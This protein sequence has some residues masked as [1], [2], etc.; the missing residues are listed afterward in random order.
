M[1]PEEKIKICALC[2][3]RKMSLQKGIVCGLTDEKPQFEEACE[4]YLVD[5]KEVAIEKERLEDEEHEIGENNTPAPE[6]GALPGAGWFK[7]IAILSILNIAL[8]FIDVSFIFGLA[9]TQLLQA[10]SDIRLI[11]PIVGVFGMIAIP[12][13]FYLTWWLTA[14]KGYKLCYNVG[15]AIYALDTVLLVLLMMQSGE[16]S[17]LIPELIFHA[18]AL[19]IGFNIFKVNSSS[20]QSNSFSNSTHKLLYLLA[21]GVAALIS[22][23]SLTAFTE[24]QELTED[25]IEAYIEIC[26]EE[27]PQDL[28]NG[29]TQTKMYLDGKCIVYECEIEGTGYLML[30]EYSLFLAEANGKTEIL[31]SLPQDYQTDEDFRMLVD[32]ML[33]YE[34]SIKYVYKA[35]PLYKNGASKVLYS[36]TITPA[37]L[38]LY[39]K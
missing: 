13:F 14:K 36:I 1:T 4:S 2:Q 10:A 5:E 32:F 26:N 12:A 38:R 3:N 39:L 37:D 29:M 35:A 15:Y 22:V 16:K 9:S 20:S 11:N 28:G 30:D 7:T 33:E 18:I 6:D 34:Y 23:A 8:Y 31:S 27:L 19:L 17:L 21:A 24:N 25:N